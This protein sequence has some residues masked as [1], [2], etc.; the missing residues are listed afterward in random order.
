MNLLSVF[1]QRSHKLF[2][3]SKLGACQKLT[4][5]VLE[6]RAVPTVSGVV[7]QDFNS[8]GVRD[9]TTVVTSPSKAT[10][11]AAVDRGIAGV[12]VTAFDGLGVNRGSA[13]ADAFGAYTLTVSGAQ[14]DP[15]RIEF[16]TLPTGFTSGPRG[17][18][19]GTSVQFVPNGSAT[20][21]NFGAVRPTDH[22][23]DN[24][25]VATSVYAFGNQQ[26]PLNA[27]KSTIVAFPYSSGGTTNA[28]FVTPDPAMPVLS[29]LAS[30]VGTTLGLGWGKGSRELYA[31]AYFKRFAGFGP[32][33]AGAIYK[34]PVPATLPANY[35]P[36]A[37]VLADLNAIP[38]FAAGAAGAN[39]H[40]AADY[41]TDN[42][43]TG[44]AAVGTS[45]LGGL[46]VSDDGQFVFV[47]NLNDRQLYRVPTSGPINS[48]TVTRASIPLTNPDTGV[49]ASGTFAPGDLRPFAVE[50]HQGKVYVGVVYTAQSR[51]AGGST[52]QQ[53]RDELLAAVYVVDPATMAFT[54]TP[55][56]TTRLNYTRSQSIY[57]GTSNWEPWSPTYFS[58]AGNGSIGIAPQP[59]LSGITFDAQGNLT[60]G[61][62]DRGADQ[63]GF[64]TLSD[65]AQPGQR[66]EG[67]TGGDTLRATVT[68]VNNLG[69]GWTIE[70]NARV[71]NNVTASPATLGTGPQGDNSGPGGGEFFYQDSF[72][73]THAETSIGG[74]A[75]IP[76]S[77]DVLTTAMDPGNVIR[78]GGLNFLSTLTGATVK[79]YELYAS[80][81][82]NN[83]TTAGTFGKAN[84]MGE[85]VI[86]SDL[87]PI[88]VGNRVFLDA[89]GDGVQGANE[90]GIAGVTVRLFAPDGSTVLGTAV[91]DANGDYIF[92]NAA[93]TSTASAIYG[94]TGLTANTA[95][96][97][98]RL[99]NPADY[100]AGG[101]LFNRIVTQALNDPSANGTSRDSD[102]V[103]PNTA[104][105][106]GGANP[107]TI[108]FSTGANGQNVHTYDAGFSPPLSLGNRVWLDT[109]NDGLRNGTPV[110]AGVSGVTV[111][112]FTA[113]GAPVG[114][115][116]TDATGYYLFTGLQGGSY[117]VEL[118]TI[119]NGLRSSTGS[120]VTGGVAGVGPSEGASTPSADNDVDNDDNG[121]QI[122]AFVRSTV[123]TLALTTEPTGEGDVGPQTDTAADASSNLT[124]DLGLIRTFSLG[125]RVWNDANNDGLLTAGEAGI[126]GV[127]VRLLD[128]AGNPVLDAGGIAVTTVTANGG[129]YR[130][131]GLLAGDYRVQVDAGGPLTGLLSSS[132]TN[133]S[134]TGTYE[135]APGPNTDTDNDDNGSVSGANFRSGVVTL[136]PTNVEPTNDADLGPGDAA[137]TPN[138]QSN[139]TVDFGFYQPV[140]LGNLVWND[141]NNNGVR[142]AGE[143]GLA[144]VPVRLFNSVG[145]LVASTSTNGT[146]I[147]TFGNLAP[148][149]YTVE[150]DLPAGFV[151]STGANGSPTGPFEPAPGPNN[152]VDNDDNGTRVGVTQTVRSGTVTLSAGGEPTTDGDGADGNLTVDF[153]AFVPLNLGNLVWNDLNNNGTRDGGEPGIDGVTVNLYADA[154]GD[155][156]PDSLTPLATTVTA[157]GG[158][159]LFNGLGQGGYVV[160]MPTGGPLAGL[161]SSSGTNGSLT[162]PFEP[163]VAPN[164]DTDNDDNGS[165]SGVNFLSGT[166]TLTVGGE[167]VAGVDGD[168]TNGNLTVDFGF[169]QPV[170]LGNLV[171]NDLNNNGVRN[172][173]EPGLAGVPVRLFNSANVQIGSTTT[174]GNGNYLFRNLIPGAYSVEADL[175]AGFVTSTGA[176]GQPTGPFEPAPSPN[177]GT[178][179][180]DNGTKTTGQT[181][182]SSPVT[183][184]SGGTNSNLTVDF[185]GFVPL[186]LGNFVWTDANNN[187]KFDAGEKGIPGVVVSLFADADANGVPDGA[188]LATFTTDANGNYLFTGLGQG[189]YVVGM[190]T[191]G[192]LAGLLSSSGTNGSLTGPYEPGVGPN[193]DIDNDDNGSL[194]GVN[195]LSGP[196]TLSPGGEPD[197]A[198][199]GDGTNGNLTVDFGFFQPL[200][201]G[202][203]VWNDFNN[204]GKFNNAEAGFA[205][206]TVRLL[207]GA[208]NPVLGVGGVPITTSTNA[209]GQYLFTNLGAGSYI[210]EVVA[211]AGYSSSL[212]VANAYEP[213]P[214]P[215]NGIDGDDNGT[216]AGGQVIRSLPVTLA[217]G[218]APVGEPGLIGLTDPVPDSSANYTV[219]FGLYTPPPLSLGNRVWDDLNNDGFRTAN[220]PGVAG[221]TVTLFSS[222]GTSL[223]ATV[224]D[225]NGYYL[226][227]NL[228]PGSYYVELSNLPAGRASSTGTGLTAGVAG[229]GP[230][231]GA[232]T[233][234]GDTNVDDDDNG[235]QVGDIVRSTTITLTPFLE[236]TRE[237]DVGPQA[238]TAT[239]INGNLTLDLGLIR[240]YS[241]GNRVWNDANNDGL[242]NT[243]TETGID[244]VTVR[245][246]DSAGNPVLDATG[247]AVTTTTVGGGYYLFG[248]LLAGDYR[249]QVDGGGPLAGY[250]SSSGAN[251]S[252]TGPFEPG[253][254][255]NTDTDSDDNGSAFGANFRSGVVTLGP[256]TS[257][258][259]GETD[260]T[261]TPFLIVDDQSNLTV[262]FGFYQPVALGN[263]VW[264][265]ANN[266]GTRD[267][268]EP[269]LGGVAVRLYDSAN[270]LVASTTTDANGNYTFG[271]LTPGAY[272]VEADLPTGF[273]SSSGTNGRPTGPYET[274]PSPANAT[275]NDDNGTTTTGQTVRSLPVTLSLGGAPGGGNVD[276]T[277]DF[278]AYVPLSLGNR[279]WDDLNNN[280][281]RDAGE[282][283]L[284]G[285][286]VTL[287][288]AASVSVGTAVTDKGGYYLFS[289]LN[290]NGYYVELSTLPATYV[291]STG[292]AGSVGPFEGANT[293][294]GDTNT[295]D[296]DNGTQV[297]AIVRST[298]VTLAV[299]TEPTGETDVGTQVNTATDAN[300][301]L[302]LDLGLTRTY[303]LGNRVWLDGNNDGLLNAG[304]AGIDGVTVR[305]L[306]AAGNPILTA[307]GTA[308]TAT[309][310]GGGYYRFD[311]L[312][313]GDYRVQV[314]GT[315]PLAGLRS[316]TGASGVA[317][318][319]GPFEAAPSPNA[320]TDN[321]D[322]GT[323]IGVNARSGVVTL[324]PAGSEPLAENDRFE[325]DGLTPDA[326][327]N[328]TVDFGFFRPVSLGN[329]V[330]I[331]ANNNGKFDAGEAAPAGPVTV[332][333]LDA[334]G[335][336]VLDGAGKAVTTTTNAAGY[337][338]F[339]GLNPGSY[340]VGVP[341]SN[342]ALGGALA[343]SRSST[344]GGPGSVTGPNE[345]APATPV[346]NNDSGTAA[347]GGVLSPVVLLTDGTAP[348]GEADAAAIP[349]PTADFDSTLTVDFGFYQPLTVG[350]LVWNDLNNTGTRDAGEPGLA[351]V[352]VRLY[353]AANVLV[354]ST[355]TD[356][357]GNYL[358]TNLT[359]G[360]YSVEADLP[361]GFKSSTG[362]TGSPTGPNEPAPGPNTDV[363]N[364]DNGTATTGQ[365][366]RSGTVTLTPG[367]EPTTDGDGT[368]GNLTVDFGGFV[369][370]SLGNL[371]WT[372]ANNNGT[373]D[374]GEKGI[375]KATVNLYAD[376]NADGV[377]DSLTPLATTVTDANGN[378][379]FTNLGQGTYVVG[380]PTGGPLAGLNSSSG[381]NGSLTGPNELAPGPNNDVDND[382]NGSLVGVNFLSGP[383][384][385]T[386]GGEPGGNVNP[387]V[388]FGFYQPL[389]LGN[390][391]WNDLNNNGVRDA[392]E[393]GLVN[394]PVRAFDAA[395]KL[396]GTTTTDAAG[397]YLFTNLT[398]GDYS[399]E[400]DLPTG[401]VSSSGTNGRP[402]GPFEPAPSPNNGTDND[403]NGTKTTGQTVR[404]SPVSLATGGTNSNPT[405]D[406][407]GYAP[408]SLGNLVWNDLNNNG[409]VD[410]GEPGLPNVPVQLFNAAGTLVTSTTTDA[411]GNYLFTNLT[412]GDYTVGVT[413][414]AGFTLSTNSPGSPNDNVDNDNNGIQ[415]GAAIRS[416][417]ITLTV[418]GEPGGNVNTTVDF[419]LRLP[420]TLAS[421]SGF[422][423]RDND[424][425]ATYTP[426]L[427]N[428]TPIGNVTVTLTGTDAAGN[429][430]PPR[431]TTTNAQGFYEFTNVP[432]GNYTITETPP[433]GFYY[434]GADNPGSLGGTSPATRTLTVSLKPND[435]GQNYNF[436]ELT[437]ADPFGYVY[438][439]LNENGVRNAGEPGIP[440]VPVTISGTA[441]AGTP[442]ARPLTAAD[443]P[444]GLTSVTN[445]TGRWE[446]PVLP[447]GLYSVVEGAV[448]APFL[449]GLEQNG[450]PTAPP[451]Q[452]GNDRFDAI[453]LTTQRVR[454]PFNFGEI[455][456]E[457]TKRNFLASTPGPTGASLVRPDVPLNPAFTVTTGTP[458]KPAYV[459]VGSGP[460]TL[461][462]VRVFDYATGGEVLRFLAYESD[463]TGGVRVATGDVNGDGVPDIITGIGV[464][465]GPRIRVFN[466]I[467]G[468]VLF[469]QFVYEPTFTGG[470][471]V[472]AAD[473]NGDG[474]A[475][476]ITGTDAGGGPRV[477]VLDG[478]T[479]AVLRDFFAFDPSQRGGVRVAAADFDKDGK[480]DVVATT[481]PGV[482]T[483]VR[484]F[485]AGTATTVLADFAPYGASFSGG[486]FVAA[487]DVNGDGVPDVVT[488]AD[489]GGGPHV[490][491]FNGLTGQ[492][493]RSY[494]AF[495]STFTGG[496]RVSLQDIDGDGRAD[497]V[498][499]AGT[500]GGPA[501]RIASGATGAQLDAFYSTDPDSLGGIYVG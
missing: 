278:G 165:L 404:S 118:S 197:T 23:Q 363:D 501:V 410:A 184:V 161:N 248:D 423:Y 448:P 196:V 438:A 324:G 67:F 466:G 198:V 136:G 492:S 83:P 209:S 360:D 426:G 15:L 258:P 110:E 216:S 75:Q 279:V 238:D 74:T 435:A 28:G 54:A 354:A 193:T 72:N 400:A 194:V 412:P 357:N 82:D 177:N 114:A 430:V 291:S 62:R 44:W 41:D 347:L 335:K 195:Y 493:L 261:E 170:S 263:L 140:S 333:L 163:G 233:P 60:L 200:S 439:D 246:L 160:G 397:N 262:D 361:A 199:D 320:D 135:P 232:N 293:P 20:S 221:V 471:F 30:Q 369:P 81:N 327:S 208:G 86:L 420:P 331:D 103:R 297:G 498:T 431:T 260:L 447:P 98:I 290:P 190:P 499:G 352:P 137:A 176:N 4:I 172:A 302:T 411:A 241:L 358:F 398:P 380:L 368:S 286:T 115:V 450:D 174:D 57:V 12:T 353:N 58:T 401:F 484:V 42:G 403:D 222:L 219:D 220:E 326:Q 276:P 432:A 309:T 283:G 22:S 317:G 489:A 104:L 88:E 141:L 249:V 414:P 228:A 167:P 344:G 64:F 119:P 443:V 434:H 183:L 189:T 330:W 112:L 223:G 285:V 27:T 21:V 43:N 274:A 322:N 39:L 129:Y 409:R 495:E 144:N 226:F 303:S 270:A 387:T 477:R 186:S 349:D 13:V 343:N 8:N 205:K 455:V 187:G 464:G 365:T 151:T 339:T 169:Y 299:G 10:V 51:F 150:A 473:I 11:S 18:D 132:G 78:A 346:D 117:Y 244:G 59:M 171:W 139:L 391:V 1:R 229:V 321:D 482:P 206:V 356:A 481:G 325:T 342:F 280:G 370:L 97:T 36:N 255:P 17:V 247:T 476:I 272:S 257:E 148:G 336:A 282:P 48:T 364:D 422:A 296:D 235:S 418:G 308:V 266:N 459:A 225:G 50:Y 71:P 315:G 334:G 461:P 45:S 267:A 164:S 73:T 269:G 289:N 52:R 470:L 239:D 113:A 231:E 68:T 465:G 316:S 47:M 234:S 456:P 479:G 277:I 38:G 26:D 154:D 451:P 240:V 152:D 487:G 49:I 127:T 446:F 153:G 147:Y 158:L 313:A 111:T 500:G 392:G 146:G 242:L 213:A 180:D 33:G 371:V 372:D 419:G 416:L 96:F 395:G 107:A 390:L 143:P 215:S 256:G 159:Y 486:V 449:D 362:T 185:S 396:V 32:G 480:A 237:T 168:G 66:I 236:P 7:F 386:P 61:L 378:Y 89:N 366:V 90:P 149:G 295:D 453:T 188:A 425:T 375:S 329:R 442:F 377:P 408:V 106:V 437:P 367:G 85:L 121:T 474:R 271:N 388:D 204:D 227:T 305:L 288:T 359:P 284:A 6:D 162:G 494:F 490:Q 84:G 300:T 488:G 382:D 3:Q 142:D 34:V 463:F 69:S 94:I 496:V 393:P 264:N 76:G 77:P 389:S 341:A 415:S 348:L 31:A 102:A 312:P 182:R 130:F 350:N 145:G 478:M 156:V 458:N 53:A 440:G 373:F 254:N 207:D 108:T 212:G 491:V 460:G 91:T 385:L 328:L 374:A 475:D 417:P 273:V 454:G 24:P 351:N 399:V 157:G 80:G 275:D 457:S 306:D 40:N 109:N 292:A 79:S 191:G 318:T 252:P 268:G 95:G 201:L 376:A 92:S 175:P 224:T 472:A 123:I 138:D 497:I 5:E 428:D 181:V 99:D 192:A 407:G 25:L 265:D 406:F 287:F 323:Q 101:P 340:Q 218:T 421:V 124:L 429:P 445:S 211:P 70:G 128:A 93:G 46:D 468:S 259:T 314:D 120:G 203:L 63:N 2:R 173:G 202:N 402:T 294:S 210:V 394:V 444:G 424:L 166:I 214:S 126:N 251:G 122:G 332:N 485:G 217:A 179:D 105:P 131:D 311:G 281:V 467:D 310:I 230:F 9:L 116:V 304:E 436:G 462:L 35:Q 155:G 245:L 55:V 298:V 19:S 125:N 355:T 483:R 413:P 469:D 381:T 301:N 433:N 87:A 337:Y 307:G 56:F 405:V 427:R 452:V 16:T 133:G 178:D 319:P 338:L 243:T 441:F 345:P 134:L 379:L 14:T 384:T 253:A 250:L 29:V 383:V 37:T 65:P 100:L